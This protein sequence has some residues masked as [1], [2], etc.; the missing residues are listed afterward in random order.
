MLHHYQ[1]IP[2]GTHLPCQR[3]GPILRHSKLR[4]QG[5][6]KNRRDIHGTRHPLAQ[7]KGSLL[8]LVDGKNIG[9]NQTPS[10]LSH[11]GFTDAHNIYFEGLAQ[12]AANG[13][14]V[15]CR[16]AKHNRRDRRRRQSHRRGGSAA[17]AS[18]AAIVTTPATAATTTAAL[19][20]GAAA[21]VTSIAITAAEPTATA[22]GRTTAPATA[23]PAAMV[24]VTAPTTV[25]APSRA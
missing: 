2:G 3:A 21:G 20:S 16:Q 19:A 15:R 18:T 9:E 12:R 6:H 24:T 5:A 14:K 8:Y 1:P 22:A 7:G 11:A 13:C 10:S 17:A 23:T 25:P 4:N